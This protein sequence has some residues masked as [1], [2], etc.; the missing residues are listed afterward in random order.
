MAKNDEI[1]LII[2]KAFSRQ[3][4]TEK[5]KDVC[6]TLTISELVSK[7]YLND[8]QAKLVM[9]WCALQKANI[10]YEQKEDLLSEGLFDNLFKKK[11]SNKYNKI[12]KSYIATAKKNEDDQHISLF[13]SNIAKIASYIQKRG[14]STYEKQATQSNTKGQEKLL[15]RALDI[16]NSNTKLSANSESLKNLKA[17]VDFVKGLHDAIGTNKPKISSARKSFK[18]NRDIVSRDVNKPRRKIDHALLTLKNYTNRDVF[19]NPTK[20]KRAV[21]ALIRTILKEKNIKST[22]DKKALTVE[23]KKYLGEVYKELNGIYNA[24]KQVQIDKTI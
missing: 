11:S 18:E 8:I 22:K 5:E 7:H 4:L 24:E 12:I 14:L 20:M 2:A 15:N 1:T 17:I 3:P 9:E 16:D 10:A 21:D 19:N 23:I 6:C 13:L